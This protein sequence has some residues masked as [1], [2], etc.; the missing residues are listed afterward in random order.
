MSQTSVLLVDDHP[1]LRAG[2]A[3]MLQRDGNYDIVGEAGTVDEAIMQAR[4]ERPDVVIADITLPDGNGID[5]ARSLK[6]E[7]VTTAV[8]LLTMHNRRTF[9]ESAIKA[10]ANGYLLKESTGEHLFQALD[11]ILAGEVFIDPALDLPGQQS[12]QIIPDSSIDADRFSA[13]SEREYEVFRLLASGQNSKQIGVLLAISSKT[14]D[15]HRSRIMEKLN[16]ESIA[17]IVRLAI[18]VGIVEP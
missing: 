16:V 11:T 12:A 3:T 6:R 13:L 15:N 7:G 18:R 1:P 9:A 5:L 4:S 8:L 10:G 17:D 2:V 14:V